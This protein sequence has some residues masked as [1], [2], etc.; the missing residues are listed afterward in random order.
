MKQTGILLAISS[1]PS[2]WGIGDLG[3]AAY[4]WIDSLSEAGVNL[5]QILPMNPL[6]YGNSP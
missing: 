2:P 5:W 3:K 6:G 4:E 1:L